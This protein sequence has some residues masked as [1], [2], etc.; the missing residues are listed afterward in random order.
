ML[1]LLIRVNNNQI[2]NISHVFATYAYLNNLHNYY[3]RFP[4]VLDRTSPVE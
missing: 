4:Q 2:T 3:V 1:E